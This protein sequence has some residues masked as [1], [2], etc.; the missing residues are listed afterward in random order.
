M[1]ASV[2]S[3][4]FDVNPDYFDGDGRQVRDTDTKANPALY[5][6]LKELAYSAPIKRQKEAADGAAAT[7]TAENQFHLADTYTKS[8]Q[9]IEYMPAA[10]LTGDPTNNATL[11][12]SI[13]NANGSLA[14]II[15]QLTTTASWVQFVPIVIPLTN[16]TTAMTP[17]NTA[18]DLAPGQSLSFAITK[19]GTGVV[20]PAGCLQVFVK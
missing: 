5:K 9:K 19:G 10:A 7:A 12:V 13:R 17:G 4:K 18:L 8:V 6:L 3:G 20:V 16:G 1:G 11:V 2:F 14:S 15:A